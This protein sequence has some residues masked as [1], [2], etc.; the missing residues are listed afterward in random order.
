M[1]ITISFFNKGHKSSNNNT[2]TVE[3]KNEITKEVK[4][5]S[6]MQ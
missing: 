2:L 4:M 6:I 5:T 1:S 3:A